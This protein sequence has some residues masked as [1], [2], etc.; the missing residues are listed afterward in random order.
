[1]MKDLAGAK[2]IQQAHT[3]MKAG[4]LSATDLCE[5][6]IKSLE[7]NKFLNCYVNFADF[8]QMRQEAE[9]AEKRFKQSKHSLLNFSLV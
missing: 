8:E 7:K 5:A 2:T 4:Y 1:M 3:M 9:A 6:T